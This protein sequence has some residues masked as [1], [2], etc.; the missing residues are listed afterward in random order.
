MSYSETVSAVMILNRAID[1]DYL[2]SNDDAA[3]YFCVFVDV[4]IGDF[5]AEAYDDSSVVLVWTRGAVRPL[6]WGFRIEK[7][8]NCEG[9][10]HPNFAEEDLRA[11][12]F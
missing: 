11:G 2:V 12:G 7:P 1:L 5:D 6:K 4:I 9:Y 10:M 3:K 8:A